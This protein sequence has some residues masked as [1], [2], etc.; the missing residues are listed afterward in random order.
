MPVKTE[1]CL[2]FTSLPE[3][4]TETGLDDAVIADPRYK[5]YFSI[6]IQSKIEKSGENRLGEIISSGIF[7][8]FPYRST[9]T[10]QCAGLVQNP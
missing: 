1:M 10:G 6:Y 2:R 9:F 5:G 7:R 3:T 4:S 8:P